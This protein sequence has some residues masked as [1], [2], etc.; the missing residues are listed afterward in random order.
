MMDAINF[1]CFFERLQ[2]AVG[3]RFDSEIVGK[4]FEYYDTYDNYTLPELM[5]TLDEKKIKIE[6]AYNKKTIIEMIKS[7]KINIPTKNGPMQEST[8]VHYYDRPYFEYS[9]RNI[10][11]IKKYGMTFMRDDIFAVNGIEWIIDDIETCEDDTVYIHCIDCETQ[12][13]TRCV[14][15]NDFIY[16]VDHDD[17]TIVDS[18]GRYILSKYISYL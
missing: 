14:E 5:Y 16:I 3:Y 7:K 2:K 6:C 13:E 15:A 1:A 10:I 8:W 12:S 17:F 18:L 11:E 4:I 9:R